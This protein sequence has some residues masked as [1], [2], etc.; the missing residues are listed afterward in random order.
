MKKHHLDA[1]IKYCILRFGTKDISTAE[2]N[3]CLEEDARDLGMTNVEYLD[4]IAANGK[5]PE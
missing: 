1:F 5:L 3:A 4:Y 2:A